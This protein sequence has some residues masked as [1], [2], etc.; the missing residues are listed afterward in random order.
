MVYLIF[1]IET[2]IKYGSPKKFI[3]SKNMLKNLPT[4]KNFDGAIQ[5]SSCKADLK[6]RL[7]D[8]CK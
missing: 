4:L 2:P 8:E 7:H 5:H 1:L 3:Q 6:P